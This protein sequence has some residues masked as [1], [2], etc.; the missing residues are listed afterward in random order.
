MLAI[1]QV[2]SNII[3]SQAVS[4]YV[5]ELYNDL[6]TPELQYH[7]LI[8]TERVVQRT[9]EIAANYQLDEEELFILS[10]AAW[11][12]DTGHLFGK[13]EQH[14][15]RSVSL[16]REFL[17]DREVDPKIITLVEG[18]IKATEV[19]QQPKNLLEEIV[20]DADTFHLG[21]EEFLI[22]DKLVKKEFELRYKVKFDN[23]NTLTLALLE[24]HKYFTP[25]CQKLLN[26]SK[27]KNIEMVRSKL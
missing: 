25:Y 8:H 19:P 17:T 27:Q 4:E 16:M 15:S 6:Q 24:S 12:H 18:C 11:F 26:G 23:W 7:N 5:T 13:P 9:Y 3:L 21:T 10:T 14:E 22:S 20:C 1:Y 2:M